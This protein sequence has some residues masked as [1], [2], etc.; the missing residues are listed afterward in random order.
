ML[1]SF[2]SQLPGPFSEIH[3]Q[4]LEHL[5][6]DHQNYRLELR[7]ALNAALKSHHLLGL[8]NA[9]DLSTPPTH[10][11]VHLSLT[12]AA[13][14]SAFAWVNRPAK[15]GIDIE[16]LERIQ[17]PVIQRVSSPI[18]IHA[19]PDMRYLWPAKEAVFKAHSDQLKIVGD[20]HIES[21]KQLNAK[22]WQFSARRSHSEQMLHGSGLICIT[23]KHLLGFFIFKG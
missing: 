11:A 2:P 14:V 17:P 8:D 23:M 1:S 18:E 22:N 3:F 21:W 9:G 12:H 20:I 10:D 13:D 7:E 6:S 19:A 16:I 15:V 5:G 4:I